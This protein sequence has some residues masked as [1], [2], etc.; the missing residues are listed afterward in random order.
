MKMLV[1]ISL[2]LII[3]VTTTCL[4]SVASAQDAAV[5][6]KVESSVA[7]AIAI[8]GTPKVDGDVDDLWADVP[9]SRVDK[10]V[11]LSRVDGERKGNGDCHRQAPLGRRTSVRDL[12][13][14]G[15][16]TCRRRQRAA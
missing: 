12:A 15:F 7:E 9:E 14:Q 4:H 6:K 13:R 8:R 5:D 2:L 16:K 3:G 1:T 10:I 11:T